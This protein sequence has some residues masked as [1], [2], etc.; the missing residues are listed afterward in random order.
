M[1]GNGVRF[2]ITDVRFSTILLRIHSGTYN[3]ILVKASLIHDQAASVSTY[4]SVL[5]T[6]RGPHQKLPYAAWVHNYPV[7][8]ATSL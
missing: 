5:L 1:D 4:T 3:W 7:D 8:F 2:V 6:F